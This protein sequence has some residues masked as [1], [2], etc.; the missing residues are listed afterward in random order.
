MADDPIMT[1]LTGST[2]TYVGYALAKLGVADSLSDKP[3]DVETLATATGTE[4]SALLQLLRT[5]VY[6]G[7]FTEAPERHFT[8]TDA[9]RQLRA[10]APRSRR[11][12]LLRNVERNG[13]ILTE[14]L[15]TM[16][17]GRPAYEKVHGISFYDR[18]ED[19]YQQEVGGSPHVESMLAGYD[20][21]GAETLV[22]V[23]GGHGDAL[24]SVLRGNPGLTGVLFDVPRN[25]ELAREVVPEELSGRCRLVA[26]SFFD[27]VPP[28][29]D[30]YTVAR[31]LHNWSDGEVLTIL[32]NI[33]A[34][35]R[36]SGR[37]LVAERLMAADISQ[38]ETMTVFLD[39]FMLLLNGGRERTEDEYRRLLEQAGFA[40][41]GVRYSTAPPQAPAESLLEAVP[42]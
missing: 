6:L 4:S 38:R 30:V 9:G 42:D 23:A 26:G 35:I 32:K 22:D 20:F 36:P 33:R 15:H 29:G 11:A 25:I 8:L 28:G 18:R 3:K 17:T 1:M 13:P 39:F 10:D 12:S 14:I 5:G 7:L 24:V 41:T 2:F 31:S 40:V 27:S 37:L 19:T 16:R 21:S 34:A